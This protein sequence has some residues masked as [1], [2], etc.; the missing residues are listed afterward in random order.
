M[1]RLI[2]QWPNG[3]RAVTETT[4]SNASYIGV[5]V[6][7]GSRNDG[8]S[9]PGLA[10]FVEHT[11][12]KGTPTRRGWQVTDRLES[13][14]GELNAYTSKEF[15]MLYATVPAGYE[16]RAVELLADLV[17]NASFP[18]N[19]V[20]LEKGVVLEEINSYEDMPSAAV[21]DQFDELV[22]TG[23]EM[24]HN[25]LGNAESVKRLTP[26]DARGFITSH[27]LPDRMVGYCSGP[28]DAE[29]TMRLFDRYFGRMDRKG[30]VP[31][32][33]IPALL[34]PFD[35]L[36]DNGNRQANTVMGW[37]IPGFHDS[38][39]DARSLFSYILGGPALNSRLNHE[40]RE[41]RGLVYTVDSSNNLYS[42]CGTFQVY[43]GSDTKN[44]AKCRRIVMSQIE[45]LARA[46]LP[47]RTFAKLQKQICGQLLVSSDRRSGNAMGLAR[48]LMV[49]GEVRDKRDAA[50]KL[51]AVTASELREA[52]AGIYESTCSVL[53]LI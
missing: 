9:T 20:E 28:S 46:P 17:N 11:I 4:D 39:R 53:T 51:R 10:H 27:Y 25:I 7:A 29:K 43:F 40:M 21:F 1:H 49:F 37:R 52:A 42:D 34:P 26:A 8:P 6:R 30:T 12:F 32:E 22:F 38:G 41:K 2:N 48:S 47:E 35:E 19:E 13:V 15:T 16:Q 23:S 5:L 50:E 18:E 14:G 45:R 3:F 33:T 31:P 36:R 44:V 24:A